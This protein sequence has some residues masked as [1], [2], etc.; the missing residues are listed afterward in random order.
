M[1]SK[2]SFTGRETM[3]TKGF[4]NASEATVD[5]MHEYVGAGKVFSKN[6][7]AEV[8]ALTKNAKKASDVPAEKSSYTS[9]FAPTSEPENNVTKNQNELNG[10]LYN[11]A[12][13]KPKNVAEA[14]AKSIDLMA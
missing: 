14:N 12:H 4:K 3:L 5:K 1:I 6:E 13:G 2:I 8:E 10:Y 7:I 9:P 11:V